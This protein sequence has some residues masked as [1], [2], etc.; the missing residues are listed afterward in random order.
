MFCSEVI[1]W[2]HRYINELAYSS[3]SEDTSGIIFQQNGFLLY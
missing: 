2:E 3:A 1:Q